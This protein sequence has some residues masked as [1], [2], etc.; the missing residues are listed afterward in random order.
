MIFN[1]VSIN[2][3]EGKLKSNAKNGFSRFTKNYAI[4]IAILVLGVVF[5][6][7]SEYFLTYSNIRNIFIQSSACLL[8][9]A[10]C[11]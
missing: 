10:R 3:E 4:V 1:S 6:F 2:A 8:Y 5:A 7:S 9:T 11:V